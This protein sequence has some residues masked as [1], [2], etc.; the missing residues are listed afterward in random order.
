[1]S[2]FKK[3]Q[4]KYGEVFTTGDQLYDI[5]PEII[6]VNPAMDIGLNGGIPKGSWVIVSGPTQLGKTTLALKIARA[7]Y[8]NGMN[9]YYN[10][11]EDRLKRMNLECL[12]EECLKDLNIIKS[13]KDKFLTGEDH[14]NIIKNLLIEKPNSLFIIDS[15]SSLCTKL[16]TEGEVD[17][18]TRSGTPRLL[19][20][21]CRKTAQIV[22][23]QNSIILLICHKISNTSGRGRGPMTM[24]D[25]GVAIQYQSDIKIVATH[26]EKWTD[27]KEDQIGQKVHWNV[28]WSALGRPNRSVWT[29]LRYG[30]GIDDVRDMIELGTDLDL[31]QKSGSWYTY[32]DCKVQGAE[33]VYDYLKENPEAYEKLHK[34]VM[35]LL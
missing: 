6:N 11:V 10:S 34:E 31:I 16:E 24:E 28:A 33:K 1:M 22:P 26:I 4:K 23:A 14:L 3:L 27:S 35:S 17:G 8:E 15:I 2:E 12:G 20:S 5:E 30:L 21:F 29:H 18:Q 32:G 9:I 19:A 25:G 7:C 13:T